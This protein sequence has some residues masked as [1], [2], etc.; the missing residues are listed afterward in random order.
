[1][2]G[3]RLVGL[4]VSLADIRPL[5]R[6][7]T[8]LRCFGA[9]WCA[10]GALLLA[11]AVAAGALGVYRAAHVV[12]MV[13]VLGLSVGCVLGGLL[14]AR[15]TG[16]EILYL[17]LLDRAPPADPGYPLETPRE[18]L[19]RT[20]PPALV[21]AFTLTAIA[22]LVV[23]AV[24]LLVGE[25]RREVVDGLAATALGVGGGWTLVCGLAGLRMASYFERWER[26]RGKTALCPPLRAGAMRH[27]YRVTGR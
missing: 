14:L 15:R 25:P 21:L 17:R 26:K 6:A 4:S 10:A 23:G 13:A 12:A 20:L 22:P 18:T 3:R 2:E 5:V 24:L 16:P 9:T 11:G 1:M 27:V 8:E 19:R 7:A